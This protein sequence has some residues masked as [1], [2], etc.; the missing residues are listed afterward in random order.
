[1]KRIPREGDKRFYKGENFSKRIK[2]S[3]GSTIYYF[4][5][6]FFYLIELYVYVEN[7]V[8]DLFADVTWLSTNYGILVCIECSGIHRDLG[9]HISRIQSLTLDK[10][11][12]SFSYIYIYIYI[13][14]Y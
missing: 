7:K 10:V 4:L 13:F 6:D 3:P 14:I 9:V 2:R 12:F 1:M 8:S 11:S 5:N